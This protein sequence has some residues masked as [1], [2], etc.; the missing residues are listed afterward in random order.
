MN[1]TLAAWMKLGFVALITG[2]LIY[3]LFYDQINGL[4]GD[5]NGYIEQSS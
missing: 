4:V 5:V 1:S 2:I 3:G